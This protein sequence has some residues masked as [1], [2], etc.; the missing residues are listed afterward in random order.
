MGIHHHEGK[1]NSPEQAL[2]PHGAKACSGLFSISTNIIDSAKKPHIRPMEN[3]HCAVI[4]LLHDE[5]F[6]CEVLIGN[7]SLGEMTKTVLV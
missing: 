5:G 1:E 7:T 2:A 4:H 6:V 3:I